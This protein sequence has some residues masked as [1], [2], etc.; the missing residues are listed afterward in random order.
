MAVTPLA[1]GRGAQ[2]VTD[3]HSEHKQAIIGAWA[4]TL[5]GNL[6]KIADSI[7]AGDLADGYTPDGSTRTGGEALNH[8]VANAPAAG[9]A[10]YVER[11]VLDEVLA[12]LGAL[13]ADIAELKG[14]RS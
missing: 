8:L 1:T 6:A 14:A 9:D 13:E 7:A 3:P 12:R 5:E 4:D 10:R 11:S 2:V